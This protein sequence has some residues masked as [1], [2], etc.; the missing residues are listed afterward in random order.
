MSASVVFFSDIRLANDFMRPIKI[1][2]ICDNVHTVDYYYYYYNRIII[3]DNSL[4]SGARANEKRRRIE[5][6][7]D[8]PFLSASFEF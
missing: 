7:F 6:K 1:I 4:S 8:V 3:G 2:I 5:N